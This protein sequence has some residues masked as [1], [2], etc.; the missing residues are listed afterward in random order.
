MVE[1]NYSRE[2]LLFR[3]HG[4]EGKLAFGH[5]QSQST[6][7]FKV[8]YEEIGQTLEIYIPEMSIMK[9]G[10]I[11][12]FFTPFKK[13]GLQWTILLEPYLARLGVCTSKELNMSIVLMKTN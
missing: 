11:S 3:K 1:E 12:G 4:M 10:S 7:I 6:F 2:N 13:N 8:P 9:I 5:F